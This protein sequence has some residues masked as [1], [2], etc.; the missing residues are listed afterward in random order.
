MLKCKLRVQNLRILAL[1]FA[2]LFLK[3]CGGNPKPSGPNPKPKAR[4][5][6]GVPQVVRGLAR[7]AWRRAR[8]S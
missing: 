3:G 4:D 5:Y 8:R 1:G 6:F 2:G 7:K